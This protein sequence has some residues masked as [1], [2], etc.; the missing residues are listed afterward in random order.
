M[1]VATAIT[2][3][4]NKDVLAQGEP[5]VTAE[6]FDVAAE[7]CR[8]R[9]R[10]PMVK[11]QRIISGYLSADTIKRV[12]AQGVLMSEAAERIVLAMTGIVEDDNQPVKSRVAAAQAA[13]HAIGAAATMM[14]VQMKTAEA[15]GNKGSKQRQ[16]VLAPNFQ[17]GGD[18]TNICANHV[19]IEQ[20]NLQVTQPAKTPIDVQTQVIN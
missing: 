2:R 4:S 13:N 10:S 9:T 17:D 6:E 5:E 8:I 7:V 1:P 15:E 12:T 11:A 18:G 19:V 3:I 20:A 14:L 16:S